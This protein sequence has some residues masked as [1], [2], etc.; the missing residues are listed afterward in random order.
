MRIGALVAARATATAW[1]LGS[2]TAGELRARPDAGAHAAA[3]AAGRRRLLAQG[4]RGAR[5]PATTTASR[6]WRHAAAGHRRPAGERTR[7]RP[8]LARPRVERRDP[9]PRGRG[10]G[11]D[12]HQPRST[13]ARSPPSVLRRARRQRAVGRR[14]LSAPPGSAARIFARR[15]SALRARPPLAQPG[16]RAP[17][18][19]CS[20]S[21]AH[22]GR[23]LRSVRALLDAQELDSRGSTGTVYWEGLSELLD[24]RRPARRPG[25]PGDD[26]LRG[27]AAA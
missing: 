11:L 9:A 23:P 10:L 24:A 18:T 7:R 1:P 12:R 19:R 4:P 16:H 20:G 2:S 14:Q 5:R 13:A 15:R 3:A 21:V 26:G 27:G 6:S 25:L 8:R 22:A 17:A